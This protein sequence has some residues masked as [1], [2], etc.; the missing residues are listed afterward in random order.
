LPCGSSASPLRAFR[1]GPCRSEQDALGETLLSNGHNPWHSSQLKIRERAV[2]Y[3]LVPGMGQ[4]R[5]V[6]GPALGQL[7][8][9]VQQLP[10]AKGSLP[11]G[12]SLEDRPGTLRSR[13]P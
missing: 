7:P 3:H 12:I 4:N 10:G 8:R 13:Q 2:N 9:I 5:A 6:L 11:G 1:A